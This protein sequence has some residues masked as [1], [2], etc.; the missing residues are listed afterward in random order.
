VSGRYVA[1]GH[2][3]V[4]VRAEGDQVLERVVRSVFVDV[5]DMDGDLPTR[6][7]RASIASL[8]HDFPA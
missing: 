4:A 7:D 6:W 2:S 1:F 3:F 5:M 8:Y